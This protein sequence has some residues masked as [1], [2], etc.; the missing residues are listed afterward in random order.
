MIEG[1]NSNYYSD[2]STKG[3]C[4]YS[5]LLKKLGAVLVATVLTSP[6]ITYGAVGEGGLPEGENIL[7]LLAIRTFLRIS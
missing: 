2:L 3:E 5:M 7:N 6:G 1:S 4:V